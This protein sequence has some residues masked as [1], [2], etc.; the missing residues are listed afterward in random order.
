[1]HIN[2]WEIRQ[3]DQKSTFLSPESKDRQVLVYSVWILRSIWLQNYYY[4]IV[5]RFFFKSMY[6]LHYL[7]NILLGAFWRQKILSS[8]V[9]KYDYVSILHSFIPLKEAAHN[10]VL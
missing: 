4:F 2:A 1:M 10:V 5:I 7:L 3:A 9:N 8:K 6:F